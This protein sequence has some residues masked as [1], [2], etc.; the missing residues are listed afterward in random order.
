MAYLE[1]EVD[2]TGDNIYFELHMF[3]DK[4][5]QAFNYPQLQL[6]GPFTVTLNRMNSRT[7]DIF[8]QSPDCS[9]DW[10]Y[11]EF[12]Y[13]SSVNVSNL[14]IT[15]SGITFGFEPDCC[16]RANENLATGG[17]FYIEVTFY[18]NLL[19]GQTTGKLYPQS[20]LGLTKFPLLKAYSNIENY[21]NLD[22]ETPFVGGDS[23]RYNL[24][25][26]YQAPNMPHIFINKFSGQA[27]FPDQGEDSAN[28]PVVIGWRGHLRYGAVK[29]SFDPGYY[30][31]AYKRK[32]FKNAELISEDWVMAGALIEDVD[33]NL[34]PLNAWLFDGDSTRNIGKEPLILNYNLSPNDTILLDL[35]ATSNASIG[36]RY[37]GDS[38]YSLPNLYSLPSGNNFQLP[39][40]T[41]SNNGG[42]FRSSIDTN[43]IVF[44]WQAA[45]DNFIYGP[46]DFE[47]V[48]RFTHDSCLSEVRTVVL[49]VHREA[50]RQ[51]FSNGYDLDTLVVCNNDSAHL[52]ALNVSNPQWLPANA[53]LNSNNQGT[54]I[55]NPYSGWI[56][57]ND[58]SGAKQD[59]VYVIQEAIDSVYQLQVISDSLEMQDATNSAYQ[60]WWI[61]G[62]IELRSFTEDKFPI[63]GAGSYH[64]RAF[65]DI[66]SCPHFSDT[67]VVP[68]SYLWGSNFGTNR[69]KMGGD[70]VVQK[71]SGG[72]TYSFELK[73]PTDS[74][75]VNN[76]YIY[77]FR[78]SEPTIA[79]ELEV[80]VLTS[81]GYQK[82]VK[83]NVTNQ[84]YLEVPVNFDLG[85]TADAR[86]Y[87]SLETGLSIRLLQSSDSLITRN[88]VDFQNFKLHQNIG[89][90]GQPTN[91]RFP[92]GIGYMGTIGLSEPVNSKW[93]M[94]PNPSSD[95][96]NIQS[97]DRNL[98]NAHF[99]LSTMQ[100]QVLLEGKLEKGRYQLSLASLPGGIYLLRLGDSSELLIKP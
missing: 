56:Y 60:D 13:S 71:I 50:K 84:D 98:A 29:G 77:G 47:F 21:A 73:M 95:I 83:L 64:S 90:P 5:G 82:S 34:A 43:H 100:G 48:F 65:I 44:S 78:N 96:V 80:Q 99:I 23:V 87:L 19:S 75:I 2:S 16:L 86:V 63:L 35:K 42:L 15:A 24:K 51:I 69:F 94:F 58:A 49:R 27:P 46:D 14:N 10:A 7:R 61:N 3:R 55:V 17:T 12:V 4:S 91:L 89:S 37:L 70:A 92:L 79:K 85:P 20:N 8:I 25:R 36:I 9:A 62:V 45:R 31:F 57:L 59:S 41:T 26:P 93:R 32:H 6:T 97:F 76:L 54:S 11:T 40:F 1:Y 53:V 52:E 18:P 67:L 22:Y 88:Y 66:R 74:R 72:E 38:S 33:T 30:V 81:Y 39:Q 68:E 28:W